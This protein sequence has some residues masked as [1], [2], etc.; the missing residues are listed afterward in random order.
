MEGQDRW[1]KNCEMSA[2]VFIVLYIM[3]WL[4]VC[5]LA[6]N[7]NQNNKQN[8]MHCKVKLGWYSKS[9]W[10]WSCH[11]L[12]A[13]RECPDDCCSW[14]CSGSPPPLGTASPSSWPSRTSGATPPSQIDA[15]NDNN[16]PDRNDRCDALKD[17]TVVYFLLWCLVETALLLARVHTTL[18][19]WCWCISEAATQTLSG[20]A[21]QLAGP[22][23]P[24]CR[25]RRRWPSSGGPSLLDP[26]ELNFNFQK[27]W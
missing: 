26:L 9:V 15:W 20:S 19:T 1:Q 27:D 13:P 8:I 23:G 21:P 6:F 10:W 24:A 18:H 12:T 5:S 17:P 14:P 22:S 2:G 25:Q 11:D 3:A 7:L 16:E 4:A